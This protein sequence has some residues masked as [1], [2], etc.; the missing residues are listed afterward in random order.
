MPT[1]YRLLIPLLLAACA[2]VGTTV[3]EADLAAISANRVAYA[4]AVRANNHDVVA[5]MYAENAVVMPANE[6]MLRGRMAYRESLNNG[7]DIADFNMSGEEMTALGG[8]AVLVTGRF[9]ITLRPPGA[10]LAISDQGKYLEVWVRDATGWKLGWDIW[11]SNL[12]LAEPAA[13]PGN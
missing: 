2:P 6:P 12:P 9:A 10:E 5:A 11:N 1:L 13:P 4:E 7:I 3:T 8:D